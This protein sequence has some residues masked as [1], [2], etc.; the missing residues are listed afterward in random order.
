MDRTSQGRIIRIHHIVVMKKRISKSV[1]FASLFGIGFIPFAPGSFGSIAA[2]GLYLLIPPWLCFPDCSLALPL[3]V[4]GISLASVVISTYAEKR[5]GRDAS[6][7]VIDELCGYF[8]AILFLPHNWLIG[9]YALVL[10]RVF[11]IA[12]PYPIFHSQDFPG[13]WGVVIDDMLA[14]VYANISLQILIRIFPSFFGL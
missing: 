5:L 6:S 7:I 1:I 14:G 2:Y 4:I 9:L 11:D 13:G 8:V 12:K 10:F 3:L